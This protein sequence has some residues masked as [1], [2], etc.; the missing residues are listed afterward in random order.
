MVLYFTGTGNSR[1]IAE[2]IAHALNDTLI[3][4]NDRIKSGGIFSNAP[5]VAL[6]QGRG[7]VP[8]LYHNPFYIFIAFFADCQIGYHFYQGSRRRSGQ[9]RDTAATGNRFL[10]RSCGQKIIDGHMGKL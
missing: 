7:L 2:R 10:R 4:L 1:H 5:Q 6:P 3:S 8:D 9:G